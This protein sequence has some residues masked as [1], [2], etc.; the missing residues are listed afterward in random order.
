MD[1]HT[2]IY[3]C[4]GKRRSVPFLCFYAHEIKASQIFTGNKEYCSTDQYSTQSA[5]LPPPG[6]HP[7]Y[8]YVVTCQPSS[9]P[10]ERALL[11]PIS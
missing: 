5:I 6:T 11:G 10:F 2:T 9:F 7:A 1:K 3:T 8:P 4:W